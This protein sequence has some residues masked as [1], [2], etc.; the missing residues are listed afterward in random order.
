MKLSIFIR[1]QQL[2]NLY[3]VAVTY[4]GTNPQT[5]IASPGTV[6]SNV[7]IDVTK[8]VSNLD[9]FTVQWTQSVDPTGANTPGAYQS[10]KAT[11]NTI[12]FE[13][14]AF[15]Y[16]KD[17]L[18]DSVSAPL[19]CIEVQVIDNSCGAYTDF[20]LKN[21]DTSW[22]EH[23]ICTFNVNLRQKDPAWKCIEQTLIGDNW[24][25]WFQTVPTNG[26]QHPRF[27]YCIE[28]RPNAMLII[29]W[30]LL[31]L[32]GGF[33]TFILTFILAIIDIVISI[34]DI[35]IT[36][37]TIG[38]VTWPIKLFSLNGVAE[39]FINI[40]VE[41]AGCGRE[42]PA[43]KIRDYIQNVCS[44][45]GINV[46]PISAPIFFAPEITIETSSRGVISTPNPH[47]NA[48]YFFPQAKRGIRRVR[49][50]NLFA[51]PQYN[52]TDFWIPE[53]S[54]V[55][56][57]D[58]FLNQLKGVYNAEW[59]I[60]N[61]TLYFWRKDWFY[62]GVP[63]YDFSDGGADRIK[64]LTGICYTWN[65]LTLPAYCTGLY[66]ND[67]AD[68]CGNEV[69]GLTGQ[70]NGI[71]NFALTD[72]NPNYY[73]SLD[74]RQPFGAAKFRL[75]GASTDYIFDAMQQL[76][77]GQLLNPTIIPNIRDVDTM[78]QQYADYAVLMKDEIC[79]LPKI[80]I[81]DGQGYLNAKAIRNVVPV[82]N[83]LVP[84]D[85]IPIINNK[86]PTLV[87]GTSTY[88]PQPWATIHQP[89]TFVLSSSWSAAKA[90][91]GVYQAADYF[92]GMVAHAAAR[93][94]NYPMYFE[95]GYQDTMWDWFHWIDD[96]RYN[97]TM[98]MT[99][100][101]KIDLCC[102]DIKRLNLLGD[103]TGANLFEPVKLPIP[104]YPI[105]II[106]QITASYDSSNQYGKSIEIQGTA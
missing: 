30:Y 63:L 91:S 39:F 24:D 83:F 41:T 40:Y 97:P 68:T 71:A 70:A 95:P 72:N 55:L 44:K 69:A 81:W 80:I 12:V 103:G 15:K 33:I 36:I 92:G 79:S 21:T 6:S 50:N 3:G 82:N 54:P 73:G 37:L 2:F 25:G 62:N 64:L 74:K 59:R 102:E 19:N 76:T 20:S 5:L 67:A 35:I 32:I 43:P 29:E 100:T 18:W 61:N 58:Q 78:L 23:N 101:A 52:N 45:C 57:L 48:C 14:F 94:V 87:D 96:P 8:Y 9:K 105:G 26:R 98:R 53:N 89:E 99:F 77:A 28:R 4:S 22:C 17:W 106:K 88:L 93:L 104:Y 27:S 51:G 13:D 31:C 49:N 10:K 7:W 65:E 11:T 34:I 85:P 75:D 46:D 90:H 42:H 1:H 84:G 66:Q 16:I 56:A 47:Y 60:K 38:L 86:Y